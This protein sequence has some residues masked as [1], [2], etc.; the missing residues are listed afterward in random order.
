MPKKTQSWTPENLFAM[1]KYI[2]ME[3]Q[4]ELSGKMFWGKVIGQCFSN[5]GMRLGNEIWRHSHRDFNY[6]WNLPLKYN[7]SID[8]FCEQINSNLNKSQA[9]PTFPI[10]Q[11]FLYLFWVS[12]IV[13]NNHENN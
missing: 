4:M 3:S 5:A 13:K 9:I 11:M 12:E 10:F 7:V 8:K 2:K 1:M 6:F